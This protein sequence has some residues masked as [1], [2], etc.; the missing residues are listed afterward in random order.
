MDSC[1]L[2]TIFQ[3]TFPLQGTT[4]LSSMPGA[5]FHISI[6]VPIAGNDVMSLQHAC[7]LDYISI[8]VPIA[9]ND[10]RHSPLP[11]LCLKFQSTF[12]LQG[13]TWLTTGLS[14]W[15]KF[16]STFPL[17]GTTLKVT[18]NKKLKIFQ[19][20]FPLQGTTF[21]AESSCC[22]IYNISIHVPIAGN[23][24]T[25]GAYHI[26]V[27]VFQSTFPLQGTTLLWLIKLRFLTI[28]IHV[29]IAGNDPYRVNISSTDTDFNPRSH[30]RERQQTYP[31][32]N[33]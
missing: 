23:D 17:Q 29:P 10:W 7:N 5:E 28:S 11:F 1:I 6:H 24:G 14:S 2:E 27:V 18:V 33:I 32:F 13:T 30:C 9:G 31:I 15:K 21:T 26:H 4:G 22:I 25:K 8:H 16:Q 19:S 12:P 3:S 20:T